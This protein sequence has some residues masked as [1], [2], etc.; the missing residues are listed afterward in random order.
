MNIHIWYEY[1]FLESLARVSIPYLLDLSTLNCTLYS[2]LRKG[3]GEVMAE[4]DRR[5]VE[6]SV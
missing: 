5:L 3:G 6:K 4:F 2:G 1:A